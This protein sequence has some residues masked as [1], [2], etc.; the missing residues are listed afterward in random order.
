MT[1]RKSISAQT[2]LSLIHSTRSRAKLL[3]RTEECAKWESALARLATQA[4]SAK[5]RVSIVLKVN[6]V[7]ALLGDTSFMWWIIIFALIVAMIALV[8]MLILKTKVAS[9]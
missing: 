2:S 1:M 5:M 8:Y 9:P 6:R 7:L 3:V 4:S